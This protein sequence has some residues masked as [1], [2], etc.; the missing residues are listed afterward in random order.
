MWLW[1]DWRRLDNTEA[2]MCSVT[3]T[4]QF[5][6]CKSRAQTNLMGHDLICWR[7][8]ITEEIRVQF[9]PPTYWWMPGCPFGREAKAT[10]VPRP[11]GLDIALS[12]ICFV[13]IWKEVREPSGRMQRSY[14]AQEPPMVTNMDT[15]LTRMLRSR[16]VLRSVID[17]VS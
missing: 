1:H 16:C 15:S 9:L 4:L 6:T 12:L 14:G 17:R 10:G 7:T 3:H 11:M 5:R 2:H 8:E 13:K